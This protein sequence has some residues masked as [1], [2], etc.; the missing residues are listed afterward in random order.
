MSLE[1]SRRDFVKSAI[2]GCALCAGCS[3]QRSFFA[4]EDSVTAARPAGLVSPGCR[5]TKV[6]V[7]KI[8]AGIPAGMWPTP[9]MDL[10]AEMANYETEFTRMNKDLA[11][12]EFVGNC[13]ATN[14]EQAKKARE[15]LANVDGVLVIHLSMGIS[16]FLP[17]LLATGKPTVLFAVPYSGHEWTGFGAMDKEKASLCCMLTGDLSQL[18]VA[19]RPFRAIHHLR[20]ARILNV[21]ARPWPEDFTKS[22]KDKFGTDV[23]VIS[24]ERALK[25]YDSIPENQA[26]AEADRWIKQ[27]MAVKEPSREEV[28]RSCRLALAF[29]K[30][31]DE[32]KATVI[33]TD[34]Y[35][36]MYRQLPAFPCV[37]NVR[38]NNMGLGGICESDPRCAMTHIILQG[39]TGRPGFISDPTMDESRNAII[40]AHCLG[41]TKMDGPDGPTAPYR[42]RTIMERQEGCVPQVFMRV[43]QPVTQTVLVGTD[44]MPYFTGTVIEVPD[45]ERGCRTKITVRIDGSAKRLWQNW[46]HGLHRVTVYGNVKEDMER[47]CKFKGIKMT[48]EAA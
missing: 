48:D 6:R 32:E 33:T 30:L 27:A 8:Y 5:G 4:P 36:S 17:E 15:A 40:L 29:E 18:A 28:V 39:L 2:A 31:L 10:K 21:S 16:P 24:R 43:N 45:T 3:S 37:G 41:S 1:L 14:V 35:G 23:V 46:S 9:R 47:F 26:Q 44:L 11:D 20:E 13:L 34:C 12:V 25:T 42:L 7:G 22:V 19:V 38:L